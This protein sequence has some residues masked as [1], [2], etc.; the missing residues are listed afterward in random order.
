MHLPRLL[1]RINRRVINPVQ[2]RYAGIIPGHGIVE[3]IGRRSGLHY[4]TPVLVFQAEGGYSMIVGYGLESDWV[5][6]LMAA[7]GG[8][9]QHRR[10]EYRLSRP[11]LLKGAESY[12]SL[13]RIIRGFARL[14]R[15]EAVVTVDAEDTACT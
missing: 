11:R 1:A 14:A 9:L 8:T 13:P 15:V 3:H 6:N 7:G 2:R 12:E 10:H 4:R 5:R